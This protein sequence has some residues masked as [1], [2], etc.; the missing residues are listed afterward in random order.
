MQDGGLLPIRAKQ[1][2]LAIALVRQRAHDQRRV[3][4]AGGAAPQGGLVALLQRRIELLQGESVR[5]QA[6]DPPST[7]AVGLSSAIVS[8]LEA[9]A[10][11]GD[12]AVT[13]ARGLA[14]LAAALECTQA[15]WT[16]HQSDAAR[17][18]VGHVMARV[19]EAA[20]RGRCEHVVI[21]FAQSLCK[22]AAIRARLD[23][24][25]ALQL[26]KQLLL[27]TAAEEYGTPVLSAFAQTARWVVQH[28]TD[29][30]A[31]PERTLLATQPVFGA[32]Q[33]TLERGVA[34]PRGEK[35]LRA[36]EWTAPLSEAYD[37]C[38]ALPHGHALLQLAIC[39]LASLANQQAPLHAAQ[40][41]GSTP[42]AASGRRLSGGAAA[43]A[44]PF[45]L[46][47]AVA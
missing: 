13:V 33:H 26:A 43:S 47:A 9:S 18:L 45:D 10:H 24:P 29:S 31:A 12:E 39:T 41:A 42:V 27:E 17:A 35:S 2:A 25:P 36:V 7:P 6:L 19:V 28:A 15:A 5:P 23:E 4:D 34:R 22:R 14:L 30:S 44:L 3:E 38:W 20:Q 16:T 8:W 11:P 40:T 1:L 46:L 32:F 37:A 21:E